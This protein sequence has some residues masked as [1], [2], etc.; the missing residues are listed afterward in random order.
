LAAFYL[1]PTPVYGLIEYVRIHDGK[2]YYMPC[3]HNP[4]TIKGDALKREADIGTIKNGCEQPVDF[5]KL[6]I[7]LG[8][9][10][11]KEEGGD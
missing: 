6:K 3:G 5:T 7:R 1:G 8:L 2:I 4:A 11:P 9:V 10:V